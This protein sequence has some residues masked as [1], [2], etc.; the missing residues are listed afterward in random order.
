MSRL[1]PLAAV[2]VVALSSCQR[3]EPAPA[4]A[5]A[6]ASARK[7]APAPA[8]MPAP[9]ELVTG[10]LP[11]GAES[12]MALAQCTIC[13]AEEYLVQQRLSPE[14]WKK[15]IAKM[16]KFG[17]VVSDDQAATLATWL[18]AL[19]PQELPVRQA[20]LAELPASGLPASGAPAR[21]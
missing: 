13:H 8:S 20:A 3:E 1:I 15:T 4:P 17:A 16:Q 14:A 9:A 18:G 21:L 5:R 2:I 19:Y 12:E 10:P 11:A 7:P 6:A